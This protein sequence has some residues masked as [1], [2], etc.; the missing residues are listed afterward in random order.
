[1]MK[2]RMK[3]INTTSFVSTTACANILR[4][5]ARCSR[6]P[7]IR[8]AIQ[9]KGKHSKDNK[10]HTMQ[11]VGVGKCVESSQTERKVY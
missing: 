3:N 7:L 5:N 1:M 4:I 2:T 10:R 6:H 8:Q 9:K 11:K